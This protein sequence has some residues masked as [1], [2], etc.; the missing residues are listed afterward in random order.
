MSN[1][2]IVSHEIAMGRLADAI[3]AFVG[4]GRR[5]SVNG[6]A[7]AT[8]LPARTISSYHQGD[9]TPGLGNLLCLIAVLPAEFADMILEPSGKGN[10]SEI[11]TSKITTALEVNRQAAALTALVAEHMVDGRIDHREAAIQEPVMRSLQAAINQYLA[12]VEK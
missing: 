2:P 8:G 11:N 1:C 5:F 12:G 3:R 10:I 6:L 9:A 7:A 4:Q